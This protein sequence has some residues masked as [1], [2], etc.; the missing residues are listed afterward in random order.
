MDAI[1]DALTTQI[2]AFG[3]EVWALAAVVITAVVIFALV[4]YAQKR[5]KSAIK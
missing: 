5:V 4:K 2:A 1:T 3:P